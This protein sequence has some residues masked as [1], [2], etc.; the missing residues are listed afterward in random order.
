[1]NARVLELGCAP[2]RW[3]AW[4]SARLAVRP[5]GLELDSRGILLT[6]TLYP[7]LP[8]V[9]ADAFSLPFA[10]NSF[11]GV[12]SIGLIEHFQSPRRIIEEARRVLEPG[13]VSIWLVPNLAE[14]SICRWH[15]RTFRRE[16]YE[17]HRC[18]TLDELSEAVTAGGMQVT[19]REHSGVYLPHSQRIMGRLPFRGVLK[20]FE[21]RVTASNL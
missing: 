17:A 3:L 4:S 6:K 11:D 19:H 20:Y 12:Y 9:R 15:W 5:T 10:A 21:H 1:C 16:N 14:G 7:Q 18:F 8:I 13:G 2:G